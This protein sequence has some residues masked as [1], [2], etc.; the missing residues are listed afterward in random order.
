MDSEFYRFVIPHLN[1]VKIFF[2]TNSNLNVSRNMK[3]IPQ[4]H[5]ERL[6]ERVGKFIRKWGVTQAG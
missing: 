6:S 4:Y 5:W 1:F 2:S 3:N